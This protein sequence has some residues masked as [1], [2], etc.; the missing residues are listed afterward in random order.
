MDI[1]I[2]KIEGD[3]IKKK[4]WKCK[5]R[6]EIAQFDFI[7][8]SMHDIAYSTYRSLWLLLDETSWEG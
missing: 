4:K 6:S 3:L 8:S 5:E 2:M 7:N 1:F